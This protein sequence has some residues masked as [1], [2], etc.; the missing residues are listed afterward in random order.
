MVRLQ[1]RTATLVAGLLSVVGCDARVDY[2]EVPVGIGLSSTN[3]TPIGILGGPAV[4]SQVIVVAATAGQVDNLAATI[5]AGSGG[6]GWLSA[7]VDRNSVAPGQPAKLTITTTPGAQPLGVYT[8]TVVL[9]ADNL[10]QPVSIA[11]RF[12]IDPRPPVRVAMATQPGG[13]AVNGTQLPQ[14]P[15]VQLFN[16]QNQPATV[17]NVVITAALASG[18]GQLTG[19]ITA[20]TD[21][22]G[23]AAFTSLAVLGSAGPKTLT[24]SA[25]GLAPVVSTPITVVAGGATQLVAESGLSQAA[26]AGTGVG[27]LPRVRVVDQSGNGVAGFTVGFAASA[28]SV[29]AP[30]TSAVS[31]ADSFAQLSS[32]ILSPVAGPNTVTA[33]AN[34]LAGSPITFS[35]TGQVGPATIFAKQSGDNSIG[36]V[37]NP[38]GTPH[39]VKV[40]DAFGNGVTGVSVT[41]G[42]TGGGSVAP[43]TSVTAANG[44]TQA[45][46][47]LGAAAGPV[48]TTATA[49]VGGAPVTLVF[50]VTSALAGPTQIVKITGDGQTGPVATTLPVPI[51]VRVLD[52]INAPQ[53]NVQVT[54]TTT[55]PGGAFPGGVTITTDASGLAA[56]TWR[57]G[58]VA[59]A[60]TAQAAVGGPAPALFSATA[61][62]GAV[63]ATISTVAASPTSIT[64]GGIGSTVT[65]TA[66]D[67]HG[68]PIPGQAVSLGLVGPATLSTNTGTTNGAGQMTATLTGTVAGAKVVSAVV[69]GVPISQSATITIL[70]AAPATM[71]AVTPT[72]FAVRFGQAVATLPRVL[73]AD[74]FGN[75][76]GAVTVTFGIT[77]GQSSLSSTITATAS[78]GT[79]S[80]SSWIIAALFAG[81]A[82]SDVYN[83]VV[84]AAGVLAPVT[85]TGTATVS[86]SADLMPMYNGS[87]SGCHI[88]QPPSLGLSSAGVYAQ[89]VTAGE[90]YVIPGDSTSFPGAPVNKNLLIYWPRPGGGV[91][92]GPDY[93]VKLATIIKAWVRQG[94][95]QN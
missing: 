50:T 83:R 25:P 38:L 37:N 21:G 18:G 82:E 78:D 66:K 10:A 70:A 91:H 71:T 32:W 4:Q 11:V 93:P 60:Q 57:L 53:P 27:T 14:Q 33:T 5:V 1:I 7:T 79:A 92:T 45:I 85:F 84:A 22:T 62:P 20:T 68:N 42:V 87:C 77:S 47:T 46:R 15:A 29:I 31:D 94:A 89:L 73:V 49:T 81:P 19:G 48:T 86:H 35:A 3:V 74:Q 30:A 52:A 54:F 16:D 2:T 9:R 41:W 65:V 44:T 26:N 72:G 61:T 12:T 8:A 64:A 63:S 28:A 75:P 13:Q 23:R 95:L 58:T 51:Q 76:V 24:F 59:G 43:A 80:V 88:G 90:R 40:T 34:G 39:V 55:T 36:L 56:T 69:A 6:A 67:I 17:A